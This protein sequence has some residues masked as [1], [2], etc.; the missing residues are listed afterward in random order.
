[1]TDDQAALLARAEAS[2]EA[3]RLL[4][5]GRFHNF[6]A[7]RA[8]YAMLYAAEALLI[9]EGLAFAKHSAVIAAF[10]ERN[11]RQ[12]VVTRWVSCGAVETW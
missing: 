6:A 8:Y 10:G 9:E 11:A 5:S 2:I 12:A 4:A 3:A 7:S 1:M